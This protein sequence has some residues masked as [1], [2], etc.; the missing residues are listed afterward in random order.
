MNSEE[1][2]IPD[3]RLKQPDGEVER[4]IIPILSALSYQPPELQFQNSYL[5][6]FRG[7]KFSFEKHASNHLSRTT[8]IITK[9]H[10]E[11]VKRENKGD[12]TGFPVPEIWL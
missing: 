9:T 6:D 3:L 11:Y 2:W 1:S 7:L 4:P 5:L 12:W 8:A 10:L